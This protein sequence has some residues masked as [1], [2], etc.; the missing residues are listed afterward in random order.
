LDSPEEDLGQNNRFKNID[1]PAVD[2]EG[3]MVPW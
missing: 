1:D 3:E 2:R